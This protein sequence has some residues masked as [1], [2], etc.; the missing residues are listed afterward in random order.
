MQDYAKCYIET[1]HTGIKN[2]KFKICGVKSN[3]NSFFHELN[4][5]TKKCKENKGRLFLWKWG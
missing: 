4:E 1:F 3:S 2:T 5:K